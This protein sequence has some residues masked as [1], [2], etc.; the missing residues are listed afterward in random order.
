MDLGPVARKEHLGDRQIRLS[1]D[2]VSTYLYQDN[3]EDLEAIEQLELEGLKYQE[4]GRWDMAEVNDRIQWL[5]LQPS[6]PF[7]LGS[8]HRLAAQF[9][10]QRRSREARTLLI[11]SERRRREA[12]DPSAS[13]RFWSWTLRNSIGYGWELWRI[14]FLAVPVVLLGSIVAWW[15]MKNGLISQTGDVSARVSFNPLV[16][17]LDSAL[18]IIKLGHASLWIPTGE[19]LGGRLVQ[20]YFWIHTI[21]G[22]LIG[23]LFVAGFTGVAHKTSDE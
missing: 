13:A 7:P 2:N 22:W 12:Q 16:Y 8:W 23:T 21:L 17:S 9:R 6:K 11:E 3:R 15:G 1:F 10:R 20:I 5:T 4:L 19:G 14:G 18:P